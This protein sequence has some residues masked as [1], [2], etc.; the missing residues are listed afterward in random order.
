VSNRNAALE[1][2]K[3]NQTKLTRSYTSEALMMH[4]GG[5]SDRDAPRLE[6]ERRVKLRL[7]RWIVTPDAASLGQLVRIIVVSPIICVLLSGCFGPEHPDNSRYE[8]LYADG[9][10]QAL[11]S[12]FP[13]G[14]NRA[15]WKCFDGKAQKEFDCTMVRGGWEQFQYI[16]RDRR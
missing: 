14:S 15:D 3:P 6:F 16:Y 2:L 12:S 7:H 11:Y 4:L 8:Y 13:K 9:K 10:F 1:T 5:E